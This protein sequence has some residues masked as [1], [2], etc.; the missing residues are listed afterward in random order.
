MEWLI[1]E[2]LYFSNYPRKGRWIVVAVYR[3]AERRVVYLA[4]LTY[5]QGGGG[6]LF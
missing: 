5:P 6:G 1:L 3:D 4:L 2:G